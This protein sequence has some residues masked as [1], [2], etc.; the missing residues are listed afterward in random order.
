VRSML[1]AVV[2]GVIASLGAAGGAR[3]DPI[4]ECGL[5]TEGAAALHDCLS[6][7]L[8]VT[9]G[10]MNE[11]LKLAR[12]RAQELDQARGGDVAVLAIEASQQAWEAHRDTA[13]QTWAV[14]AGESAPTAGSV[15]LACQI[16]LTRAR[17]DA[18]L[19][20]ARRQQAAG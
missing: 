16:E 11:A 3:A 19:R 8:E 17:G 9:Y 13:C 10:A 12:G 4:L 18:L 1:V 6:K 15:E 5:M 7:Q 20:L 2:A 14:F